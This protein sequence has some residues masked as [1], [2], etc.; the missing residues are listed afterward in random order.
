MPQLVYDK[1][2]YGYTYKQWGVE[3]RSLSADLIKRFEVRSKNEPE[4]S[5]RQFQGLPEPGYTAWM[6]KMLEG[7]PVLCGVDYLQ[8][9][10]NFSAHK[11]VIFTGPIDEYFGFDLGRLQY[12]SQ[13]REHQ[14]LSDT[15][16]ALPCVQVNNPSLENDLHIRTLEW[17]HLLASEEAEKIPGTLLTREYPYSPSDPGEYEYPFPDAANQALYQQYQTRARA[18]PNLLICGRLG[19]YR[20]YDMDQAIGRAMVLAGR[21]VS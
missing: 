8:N 19:E 3:P 2:V 18:I 16:W 9:R 21:V 1:F 4:L 7:I 10:S 12:R 6:Q 17:K 20:Y 11:K 15:N 14:F 5:L 13:R